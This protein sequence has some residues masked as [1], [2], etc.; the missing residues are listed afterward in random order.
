MRNADRILV[1]NRGRIIESG[2]HAAAHGAAAGFTTACTSSSPA[3]RPA[4]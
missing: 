4:Q 1:M 3:G 2:T